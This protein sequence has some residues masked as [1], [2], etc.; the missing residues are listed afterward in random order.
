MCVNVIIIN[1]VNRHRENLSSD[2]ENTGNFEIQFEGL[3]CIMGF[4]E[5]SIQVNEIL[6][7]FSKIRVLQ[8][9]IE[10]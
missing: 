5:V 4:D 6:L 1:H 7:I 9:T 3:P 8:N 2:R 10:W